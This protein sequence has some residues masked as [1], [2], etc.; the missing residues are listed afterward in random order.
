MS[1]LQRTCASCLY[2]EHTAHPEDGKVHSQMGHKPYGKA[3]GSYD[4]N[5]YDLK[6]STD[7]LE[8]LARVLNTLGPNAKESLGN[9]I[10]ISGRLNKYGFRFMQKVAYQWRGGSNGQYLN[11]FAYCYVLSIS[12]DGQEL[13]LVSKD[14]KIGIQCPTSSIIKLDDF[15]KIRDELLE[16]GRI[17]DPHIRKGSNI[18]KQPSVP[19]I[20]SIAE[21]AADFLPKLS[22]FTKAE[23]EQVKA[24]KRRRE[25]RAAD[26]KTGVSFD[27]SA[28]KERK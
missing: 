4:P 5:P 6:G 18:T 24:V 14:R 3:C 21:I 15:Q 23:R 27:V 20:D 8:I 19:H 13:R 7:E 16:Q 28:K 1:K 22:I 2:F 26:D 25:G 12:R 11:N 17:K 10:V 9:L